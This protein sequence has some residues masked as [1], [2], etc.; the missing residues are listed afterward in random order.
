MRGVTLA[1]STATLPSFRPQPKQPRRIA[2]NSRQLLAKIGNGQCDSLTLTPIMR[3][4][5]VMKGA[6][7][8]SD[9]LELRT[10]NSYREREN[11]LRIL[12]LPFSTSKYLGKKYRL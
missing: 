12:V 2:Q 3:L 5:K 4:L 11:P 6:L 1:R 9:L 10:V 7:S 8:V